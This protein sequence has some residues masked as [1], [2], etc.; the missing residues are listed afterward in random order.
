MSFRPKGEI[1]QSIEWWRFLVA[2]LLRNDTEKQQIS[3]LRNLGSFQKSS[4]G[5]DRLKKAVQA[6]IDTYKD[7]KAEIS[8]T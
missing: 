7:T 5:K 6:G 1:F 4:E 3:L 8:Q 2:T